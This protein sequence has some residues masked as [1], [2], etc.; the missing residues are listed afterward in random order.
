MW[1]KWSLNK[2]YLIDLYVDYLTKGQYDYH[3]LICTYPVYVLVCLD[4]S[5]LLYRGG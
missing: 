2:D 3:E 4:K 5:S 1:Y